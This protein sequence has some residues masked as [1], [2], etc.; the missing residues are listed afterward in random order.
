M[1]R[2]C[3]NILKRMQLSEDERKDTETILDKLEAHF[4][5]CKN[6]IYGSFLFHSRTQ[7]PGE[8]TQQYVTALQ[9][10]ADT[11]NFEGLRDW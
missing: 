8:T 10:W 7:E 9:E 11:C 1:G 2:E 4:L 3:A 5:P 6:I